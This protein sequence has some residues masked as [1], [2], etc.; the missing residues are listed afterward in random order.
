MTAKK[1]RTSPDPAQKKKTPAKGPAP[2]TSERVSLPAAAKAA[3]AAPSKSSA[4]DAAA[5]V[6]RESGQPMS[7]PELIEQ[8]A[9]KGYWSSPKGK[10]PSSTLYAALTREIRLKGEAS[11]FIKIGPGRFAHRPDAKRS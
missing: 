5:R 7:C 9:A 4:L 2:S 6:L 3:K 10:T 11:R 1:K 8:M